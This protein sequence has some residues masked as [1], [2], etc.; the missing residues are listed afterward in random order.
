MRLLRSRVWMM[1]LSLTM[2]FV[3]SPGVANATAS[4][5]AEVPNRQQNQK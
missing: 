2:L 1:Q 5:Q 4:V 3:A